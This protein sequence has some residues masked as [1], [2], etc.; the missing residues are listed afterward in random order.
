M[1]ELAKDRITK[2]IEEIEGFFSELNKILDEDSELNKASCLHGSAMLLFSIINATIDI[3]D[4]IKFIT[5][6]GP[7][8]KYIEI[9]TILKD[10]K[11]ITEETYTDFAFLISRRNLLAHEYGNINKEDIKE[12]LDKIPIVYDMIGLAKKIIKTNHMEFTRK[13]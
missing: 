10:N 12:V 9:F 5:K 4:D 11:L 6:L 13:S 7:S 8:N 2:K 3:A 1:D